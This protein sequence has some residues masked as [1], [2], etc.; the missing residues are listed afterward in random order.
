MNDKLYKALRIIF[1]TLAIISMV[2]GF[3]KKVGLC[4]SDGSGVSYLFQVPLPVNGSVGSGGYLDSSLVDTIVEKINAGDYSGYN[5]AQN[6]GFNDID[7]LL[8]RGYNSS[9]NYLNFYAYKDCYVSSFSFPSDFTTYSTL[10]TFSSTGNYFLKVE[11]SLTSGSIQYVTSDRGNVSIPF[12]QLGDSN[13]YVIQS[14]S[15]NTYRFDNSKQ[16]TSYPVYLRDGSLSYNDSVVFSTGGSGSGDTED[17]SGITDITDIIDEYSSDL[18]QIDDSDPAD[19]ST[20]LGWLKKILTGIK[21][22]GIY[23][24]SSA[25]GIINTLRSIAVSI[26]EAINRIYNFI[27]DTIHNLMLA[28]LD[29]CNSI[30]TNLPIWIG[31]I[32]DW[33]QDIYNWLYNVLDATLGTLIEHILDILDSIHDFFDRFWHGNSFSI[34][35]I[36]AAITGLPAL[37]YSY[38]SSF[39]SG[40]FTNLLATL[41]DWWEDSDS[42]LPNWLQELSR[43]IHNIYTMGIDPE[44]SDHRFSLVTLLVTLFEF[45]TNQALTDFSNNKY[46]AFIISVKSFCADF[47]TSLTG[48]TA[49]ERVF[50]TLDLGNVFDNDYSNVE[51]SVQPITI[52]FAWYIQPGPSGKSVRDIFIPVFCAFLYVS[53]V[54]LFIKRLPDIL[55]GVAGAESSFF[56]ALGP[57]EFAPTSHGIFTRGVSFN[58]PSLDK[59]PLSGFGSGQ[60]GQ[61]GV[62]SEG[63]SHN[64]P[65]L[66]KSPLSGSGGVHS[67]SSQFWY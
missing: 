44:D 7:V 63:V 25:A 64:Q 10:C 53:C 9:G 26:L 36:L 50:F 59:N 43:I 38:F 29:F 20:P 11:Y 49:S 39:I 33:V 24:V 5:Y 31:D 16:I 23:I 6:A 15:D 37:I 57:D 48:I 27:S 22:L 4:A 56:D 47:V 60:S 3:C 67:G 13:C 30:I 12:Y 17:G 2:F 66:D 55:R 61:Y 45:N 28:Y 18:P 51:S 46:G 58:Q 35:E 42:H 1:L 40:F 14:P 65:S 32:V 21:N 54:W 34:D 62:Y 41:N 52:D 19:P 8:F